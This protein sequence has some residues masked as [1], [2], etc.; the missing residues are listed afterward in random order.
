MRIAGLLL[1]AMFCAGSPADAA[2]RAT[3]MLAGEPA[4]LV[5]EIDDSGATR[6]GTTG[7]S[8]YFLVIGRSAY[9]V[10]GNPDD[11]DDDR[12]VVIRADDLA[13]AMLRSGIKIP[14]ERTAPSTGASS[15]APEGLKDLGKTSVAGVAGHRYG[16]IGTSTK[17]GVMS[18]LT[19]ADDPAL[20]RGGEAISAALTAI[21]LPLMPLMDGDAPKQIGWISQM[22]PF[23]ERG[24]PLAFD[25][26]LALRELTRDAVIPPARTTLPAAPLKDAD[27]DR[28]LAE[29]LEGN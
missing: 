22:L 11:P 29:R 14:I 4:P 7:G 16:M 15:R 3:Y 10:A 18:I 25:M 6:L 13:A 2:V 26:D 20:R 9:V 28:I 24:L 21:V 19:I 23:L 17:S 5:V 27:I 1:A 12:R 8:I